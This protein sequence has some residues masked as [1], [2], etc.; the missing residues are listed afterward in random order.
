M[1]F[2]KPGRE[3]LHRRRDHT[4]LSK[5]SH[6]VEFAST[7]FR[8]WMN[9]GFWAITLSTEI[10]DGNHV[11]TAIAREIRRSRVKASDTFQTSAEDNWLSV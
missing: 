2:A 7:S 6:T 4:S 1:L 9:P 5:S 3:W 10:C 11:K 8:S